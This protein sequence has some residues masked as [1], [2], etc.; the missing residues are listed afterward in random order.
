MAANLSYDDS[1]GAPSLEGPDS[2]AA[3]VRP[4]V[5]LA[6]RKQPAAKITQ[7]TVAVVGGDNQAE[8]QFAAAEGAATQARQAVQ[9]GSRA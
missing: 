7:S 9:A 1:G 8:S 5:K 2:E 4:R 6:T 3:V